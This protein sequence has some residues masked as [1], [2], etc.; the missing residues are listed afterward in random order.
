MVIT[1]TH[2]RPHTQRSGHHQHRCTHGARGAGGG[3]FEIIK[4]VVTVV[5]VMVVVVVD[6]V[7][8]WRINEK[9]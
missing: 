1:A 9:S 5:M 3:A 8:W 7:V 6:V 4:G 2:R